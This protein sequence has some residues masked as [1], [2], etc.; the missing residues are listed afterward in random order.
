MKLKILRKSKP[1][2]NDGICATGAVH[3]DIFNNCQLVASIQENNLVVTLGK[4]NIAKLLGG[5]SAGKAITKI[6]IGTNATVAAPGDSALTDMF[7][8]SV[9][10][11]SFPEANSVQFNFDLNND[12]GNGITIREFGLLNADNILCA[13]KVRTGEIEKTDA[14]RIVGSWKITI[15]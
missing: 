6:G 2:V 4:T 8:K 3:I 10:S 1:L 15:N 5:N 11:V 12:E 7:S 9:D 14:I 13:R